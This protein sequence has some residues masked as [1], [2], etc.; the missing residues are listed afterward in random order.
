MAEEYIQSLRKQLSGFSPAEQEALIEEI[1][2]HIESGEEDLRMG[3]DKEERRTRIMNELGSPK[4]LGSR[5]RAVYRPGKIIDYLLIL[6]PFLFYPYLSSFY[7]NIVMPR[8]AGGALL[9]DVMIHL[10]LALFGLWRRSAPVTFFWSAIAICQLSI[11]TGRLYT[12]YGI[13]TVFWA[14]ILM[15]LLFLVGKVTWAQRHDPLVIAFGLVIVGMSIA[16]SLL[17]TLGMIRPFALVIWRGG[18]IWARYAANGL[19]DRSLLEVYIHVRDSS[20]L[21]SIL[22]L[23]LFFIPSNREIR[24][25]ALGLAGLMMGLGHRFLLDFA[26]EPNLM[27][28]WVY[29]SWAILPILIALT[30]WW[31]ERPKRQQLELATP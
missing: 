30:G 10:A 27:A 19:L 22:A 12:Y 5:F 14:I 15:G 11:I 26:S 1:N 20:I 9:L 25:L 16:A 8:Y 24:W 13:Q 21:Y 18:S 6:I 29:F 3:R 31:L 28:P 23:A 17:N 7:I 4:D 2:S